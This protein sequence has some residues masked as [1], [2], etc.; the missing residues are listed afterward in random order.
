MIKMFNH[1]RNQFRNNSRIQNNNFP[2]SS[3][4]NI[5]LLPPPPSYEDSIRF[6]HVTSN[7]S[8][9][10]NGNTDLNNLV[11]PQQIVELQSTTNNP[12]QSSQLGTV[13]TEEKYLTN[14]S[15]RAE[16]K[17]LQPGNTVLEIVLSGNCIIFLFI[18]TSIVTRI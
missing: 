10:F 16:R 11:L 18:N 2:Q 9:T 13:N 1:R 6:K 15:V 3:Q 12:S 17:Q 7:S 8:T 5:N 4:T 14:W